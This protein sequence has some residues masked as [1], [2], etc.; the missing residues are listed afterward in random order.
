MKIAIY[1]RVSTQ[2][3]NP[4]NQV[5][6]LQA[7][8]ESEKW[9]YEIFLEKESTRKTR[10]VKY[11][12]MQRLRKKEF[13]GVMILKLDR[14]ARSTL[15]LVNEVTE[16]Y[17]KNIKFISQRENIDF[18]TSVGRLQFNIFAAF[19]QFERDLISERTLDG[20]A[21]ARAEGRTGG[22]PKGKKDSKPRNK[23]GYYA[24]HIKKSLF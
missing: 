13:D 8:A 10:P 1:C 2:E 20:L 16:L 4:E 3:Q 6:I 18:S 7:R 21:R 9:E 24:R 15:E 17:E 23:S 12:L 5:R 19:A 22:R 14:W 11:E